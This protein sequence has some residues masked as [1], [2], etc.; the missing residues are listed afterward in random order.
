MSLS[1]KKGKANRSP[2][3]SSGPRAS[4]LGWFYLFP[5]ILNFKGSFLKNLKVG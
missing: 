4:L 3:A 5:F 1:E 2:A